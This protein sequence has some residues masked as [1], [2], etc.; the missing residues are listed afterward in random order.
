MS[1]DSEFIKV[2]SK[3]NGGVYLIGRAKYEKSKAKWELFHEKESREQEETTLS[4]LDE[5]SYPEIKERLIKIGVE[6]KGNSSKESLLALLKG[7]Q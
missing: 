7:V 5:L 3:N 1:M 6:F 2:I 4:H